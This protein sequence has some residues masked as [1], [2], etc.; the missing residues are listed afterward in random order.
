MLS[1]QPTTQ[2]TTPTKSNNSLSCFA[3]H[4]ATVNTFTAT[5]S[6]NSPPCLGTRSLS[7]KDQKT[8]GVVDLTTTKDMGRHVPSLEEDHLAT[9]L[10]RSLLI[11]ALALIS[12]DLEW[13]LFYKT[14][15]TKP[16]V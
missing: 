13:D 11:P 1:P 4:A 16:N 7:H 5:A 12:P 14:I 3:V 10:S 6:S 2:F 8:D 15:S 9:E